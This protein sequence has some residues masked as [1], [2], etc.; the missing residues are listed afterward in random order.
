MVHLKVNCIFILV[1]ISM[2]KVKCK[3]AEQ[4]NIYLFNPILSGMFQLYIFV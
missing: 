3:N 4:H 2:E 1:L